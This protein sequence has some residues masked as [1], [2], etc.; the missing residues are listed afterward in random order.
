MLGRSLKPS[1]PVLLSGAVL[2]SRSLRATSTAA[3]DSEI[4]F[5]STPEAT[6]SVLVEAAWPAGKDRRHR[7]RAPSRCRLVAHERQ[8]HVPTRAAV[9]APSVPAGRPIMGAGSSEQDAASPHPHHLP[10]GSTHGQ[11]A[12]CE[13]CPPMQVPQG[14]PPSKA[15][16]PRSHSPEAALRC[17][18]TLVQG[19]HPAASAATETPGSR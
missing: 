19:V 9:Q 10:T 17:S 7:T 16:A 6:R 3:H 2:S 15:P 13:S 12:Q 4:P 8:R 11:K 5:H 14:L 18:L 1:S